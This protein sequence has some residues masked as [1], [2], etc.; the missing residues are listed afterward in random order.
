M[1]P[2]R[3]G[4]SLYESFTA[5]GTINVKVNVT[6]TGTGSSTFRDAAIRAIANNETT[7]NGYGKGNGNAAESSTVGVNVLRDI[8]V[9]HSL[10]EFESTAV[11]LAMSSLS[12]T[13]DTLSQLKTLLW[14]YVVLEKGCFNAVRHIVNLMR[15]LASV[16]EIRWTLDQL[17]DDSVAKSSHESSSSTRDIISDVYLPPTGTTYFPYDKGVR[18]RHPWHVI[19]L[20]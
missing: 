12:T 1:F 10:Q 8:L 3:V 2:N 17:K 16:K 4:E 9:T 5:T 18:Q 14:R 19:L 7:G 13:D 20:P 11:K 15:G 6:G